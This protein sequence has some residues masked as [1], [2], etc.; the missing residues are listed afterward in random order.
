MESYVWICKQ[1]TGVFKHHIF[2][3]YDKHLW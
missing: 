1:Q 3:I 2:F